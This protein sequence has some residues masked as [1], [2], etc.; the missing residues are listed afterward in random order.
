MQ[1]HAGRMPSGRVVRIEM[2]VNDGTTVVR[3][4]AGVSPPSVVVTVGV[5]QGGRHKGV[6]ERG[7]DPQ[8]IEDVH[9]QTGIVRLAGAE[10]NIHAARC[11][12]RSSTC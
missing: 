7:D 4:G 3:R 2:R 11:L 12:R 9:Q 8:A 10:V 5:R 6:H 1:P